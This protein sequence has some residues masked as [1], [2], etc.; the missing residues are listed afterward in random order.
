MEEGVGGDDV[1]EG[2]GTTLGIDGLGDVGELTEHV[3]T[4]ELK[5]QIAVHEPLGEA[6]VPDK[7]VG[8]HRLVTVASARVHGQVGSNLEIPRQF[9]LCGQA[10]V[11][12]EDIDCGKI[13]PVAGGA[14][15]VKVTLCREIELVVRTPCKGKYIVDVVS[16]DNTTILV[17]QVH[18]M[19]VSV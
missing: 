2:L 5:K 9:N 10:I 17:H 7:I 3:E 12:V 14:L 15:V 1:V 13:R 4:I 6:S 11:E 8:I 18:A 19:A 16:L